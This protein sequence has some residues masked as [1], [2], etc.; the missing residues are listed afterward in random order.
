M[1]LQTTTD[2]C[3][4]GD[5]SPIIYSE[6]KKRRMA[7]KA[8]EAKAQ[9]LISSGFQVPSKVVALC[10]DIGLCH[11]AAV[12]LQLVKVDPRLL[13]ASALAVHQRLGIFK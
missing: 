1:V 10:T 12:L 4:M 2:T 3:K 9:S 8:K 11:Q 7:A 13:Q 5:R 6:R